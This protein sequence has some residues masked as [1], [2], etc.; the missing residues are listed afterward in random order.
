MFP[1]GSVVKNSP[2]NAGD[3]SSIPGSG[4]YPLEEEMVTNPLQHSCLRNPMDK[5][6][7]W[8]TFHAVV[9]ESDTTDQLSN[10]NN[11][12]MCFRCSTYWLTFFR[13]SFRV[14]IKNSLYSL[15]CTIFLIVYFKHKSLCL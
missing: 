6:D 9:K 4:R 2:A 5:G 10:S 3:T 15:G 13:S 12:I 7:C 11:N 1:D 14:I 8:A